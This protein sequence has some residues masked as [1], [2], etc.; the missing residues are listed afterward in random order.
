[1][2]TALTIPTAQ[3]RPVSG[4]AALIHWYFFEAPKGATKRYLQTA[5]AIFEIFS[6]M[7]LF[8]TMFSRW[9]GISEAYPEKGFKPAEMLSTLCLN[10]TSRL[11]GAAVRIGAI[12]FTLILQGMLGAGFVA[13][14]IAWV[15]APGLVPILMLTLFV[16]LFT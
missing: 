2:D 3:A 6:V 5:E 11:I 4:P 1:M 14:Q 9:K 15:L 8:R 16:V 7:F 12:I 13:Y 10:L